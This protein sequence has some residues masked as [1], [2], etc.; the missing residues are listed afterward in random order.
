MQQL[1]VH[2][3]EAE[4]IEIDNTIYWETIG[5]EVQRNGILI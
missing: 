4:S 2:I 1:A 3:L 5:C